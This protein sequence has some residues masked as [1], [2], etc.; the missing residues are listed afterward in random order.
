MCPSAAARLTGASRDRRQ[1]ARQQRRAGRVVR[2]CAQ[3]RPQGLSAAVGRYQASRGCSR[4]RWSPPSATAGA[5]AAAHPQRRRSGV[6]PV[7]RTGRRGSRQPQRCAQRFD[8]RARVQRQ[9]RGREVQG[10]QITAN[11]SATPVERL[12]TSQVGHL[13]DGRLSRPG[14]GGAGAAPGCQ[15]LPGASQTYTAGVSW[16]S[17]WAPF[18]AAYTTSRPVPPG[19]Q[20]QP[21]DA[22][23]E[24]ELRRHLR[25]ACPWP[26]SQHG[27]A[28][29]IGKPVFP[30]AELPLGSASAS[31]YVSK[32]GNS[33]SV[34]A[35]PTPSARS[36][37]GVSSSV[38]RPDGA[39][40]RRHRS[41]RCRARAQPVRQP[42]FARRRVDELGVQGLGAGGAVAFS[43]YE[44]GDTRHRQGRRPGRVEIQT[45]S[46]RSG[47]TPG[48]TPRFRTDGLWRK[49]GGNQHCQP[50]A[51]RQ[52]AER[53]SIGPARGSVQVLDFNLRQVQRY[54]LSAVL[55]TDRQPLAERLPVMDGRGNPVTLV[56]RQGQIFRRDYRAVAR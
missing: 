43:P 55:E 52:P 34:G 56:G 4:R 42:G 21:R 7:P 26:G 30:D 44:V 50:A 12:S 37:A 3:R 54:L 49:L 53:R 11:L 28:G 6:R 40:S 47:R 46:A 48:A 1:R 8:R 13:A 2:Q 23:L 36:S 15:V 5:W 18:S 19:R 29:A 22:V 35:T 51:Q 14:A 45:P 31:T 17:T 33:G 38:A 39:V 32:S 9:L 20:A 10:Q 24:P 27:H 16:F 25:S 41:T